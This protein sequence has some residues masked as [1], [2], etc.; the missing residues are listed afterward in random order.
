MSDDSGG[1]TAAPSFA[2]MEPLNANAACR[3]HTLYGETM[4]TRWRVDLCTARH[5]A[6]EALHAGIQSRLDSVV[7]QMSTWER[8]SD[9]CRFNRA[10]AGTRQVL[11]E[12][13]STV[14]TCALEVARASG[15]A[16]DPT[17]GPLVA[18][19]GFGADAAAQAIPHD[20][21]LD[22]LRVRIG[23]QRIAFDPHTRVACQPGGVSLD[24]SAIA[25]GFAVDEIVTWLHGA[26]I[27]AALVDVGGELRGYGRKPDGMPWRVLVET[28]DDAMDDAMAPCVLA[29]HDRAVATS[30]PRWHHYAQAGRMHAHTIDL[31]DGRPVADAAA[32]VTVVADDAMRADA[33]A[34]ALTVMGVEAGHAFACERG[35]AARFVI[36]SAQ[37][38]SAR[39]VSTPAFDACVAA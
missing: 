1:A 39:V 11:P 14:L 26:G 36:R 29:L 5:V 20:V 23:W 16:F 2:M 12:A 13:F 28:G 27:A 4:G 15:G 32:A 17:V 37:E 24:L 35:L 31:R 10:P 22:A 19:W 33:W 21:P 38:A 6:L 9:I 18:A 30:G 25:K 8:D 3:V 7:A 34:T